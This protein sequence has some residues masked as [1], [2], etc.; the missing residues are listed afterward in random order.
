[1]Q[2]IAWVCLGKSSLTLATHVAG[3]TLT[4]CME[5]QIAQLSK[6]QIL[7]V[8]RQCAIFVQEMQRMGIA[9][10]DIC[11][12][13]LCLDIVGEKVRVTLTNFVHSSPLGSPLRAAQTGARVAPEV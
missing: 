11:S 4:S 12:D 8:I 13:S 3:K 7:S 1:M 5:S 9:H 6:Y 10:N 2:K